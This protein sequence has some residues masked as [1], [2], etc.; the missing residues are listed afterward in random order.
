MAEEAARLL[1]QEKKM[2][3]SKTLNFSLNLTLNIFDK[4]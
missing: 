3:K 2:K 4:K 1:E